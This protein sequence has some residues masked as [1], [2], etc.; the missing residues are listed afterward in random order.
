M[1]RPRSLIRQERRE[2]PKEM[3]LEVKGKGAAEERYDPRI[4]QS[5]HFSHPFGYPGASS[6]TGF[7][8]DQMQWCPSLM[9]PAYPIWDPYCQIWVNY[10]PMMS[11][12]PWGWGAP[13]QP[14]FERME[15][16]TSDRVDSSSGQQSVEPTNEGKAMLKSEIER[17]TTDN[18]IKIGTSQVKLGEEFNGPIIFDDQA[19][20]NMEDV[21]PDRGEGKTDK[22]VDSK[23]LQQRWCPPSL[24]RTKK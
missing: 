21:T 3:K 22:V 10:P 4:S 5:S 16:P 18:V 11:M 14:V 2:R 12:T 9:M 6:S 19:D 7:P 20:T 24:T 17:T 23:Y 1:K 13:H 15:F 8:V